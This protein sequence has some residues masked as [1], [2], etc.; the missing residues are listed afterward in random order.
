MDRVALCHR[1]ERRATP[2]GDLNACSV[3]NIDLH[4][5]LRWKEQMQSDM[6]K[7]NQQMG[8]NTEAALTSNAALSRQDTTDLTC[9]KDV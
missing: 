5:H 6:Q 8:W 7:R 3:N 2:A 4:E 9:G 1:I